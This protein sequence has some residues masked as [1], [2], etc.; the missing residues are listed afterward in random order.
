[1]GDPTQANVRVKLLRAAA[2]AAI[3]AA[4]SGARSGDVG[5]GPPADPGCEVVGVADL[6]PELAE[7]S[8]VARDPRRGDLLWIHDDEGEAFAL[9]A[10]DTAG[11]ALGRAPIGEI[12]LRDPEDLALGRCGE[13]WCLY[14]GD[15]GDNP[16]V[17]DEVRVH[18]LPLPGVPPGEAD[19]RGTEELP[20]IAPERTWTFR[21]PDGPRDA[22]ALAVDDGVGEL[23]VISKGWDGR[24]IVYSAPLSGARDGAAAPATLVRQ[25]AL[26]FGS[27][28]ES[29]G[30]V[31]GAD[32]SP[33][34]KTLAVRTYVALYLVPWSGAAE[35]GRVTGVRKVPLGP[36]REPQGEGVAFGSEP[37]VL[38]LVSESR[39]GRPPRLSRVVCPP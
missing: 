6:P 10:V 36:A 39:W 3:V 33:D 31:T 27:G 28:G 17:R 12:G 8:G 20:P 1:M 29:V 9:V 23:I 19:G 7:A 21:Y 14:L 13:V 4:V 32:L 15:I 22:E 35:F 2:W 16:A 25:G 26:P 11:N 5:A 24:A 38:H 18:R 30:F 34:G 37:G